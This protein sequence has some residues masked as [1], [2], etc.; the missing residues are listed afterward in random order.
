MNNL[1]ERIGTIIIIVVIYILYT[2]LID[3]LLI[4]KANG[5]WWYGFV[6]LFNSYKLYEMLWGCGW[7]FLA[8]VISYVWMNVYLSNNLLAD[9]LGI[10]LLILSAVNE[11]K[12]AHAFE[13]NEWWFVFGLMFLP[14]IFKSILAFGNATYIGVP[15]DGLTWNDI[16][17]KL[18]TR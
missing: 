17:E 11:Y 12:M 6:P 4:R 15:Q 5:K 2:C 7:L 8:E 1:A 16:K 9:L 14:V 18:L 10:F 13:K 3:G